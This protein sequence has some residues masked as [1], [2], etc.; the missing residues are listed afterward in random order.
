MIKEALPIQQKARKLL[1][2]KQ[3]VLYKK[4]PCLVPRF[5]GKQIH[6]GRSSVKWK[7]TPWSSLIERHEG[8]YRPN[9][10]APLLVSHQRAVHK[11]KI[12]YIVLNTNIYLI[13]KCNALALFTFYAI[14][15]SGKNKCALFHCQTH[16]F[17]VLHELLSLNTTAYHLGKYKP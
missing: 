5:V 9:G 3:N 15:S 8:L 12:S 11:R 17:I 7:A 2:I 14:P 1:N 10:P 13:F 16:L 4:Q 6:R